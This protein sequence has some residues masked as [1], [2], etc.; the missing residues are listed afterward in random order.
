MQLMNNKKMATTNAHEYLVESASSGP[1]ATVWGIVGSSVLAAVKIVG[2][3]SYAAATGLCL[4]QIGEFS[5]VLATIAQTPRS[6][7]LI[8]SS[9]RY[10]R[11]S[12]M[13]IFRL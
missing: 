13:V 4:A 12:P 8:E 1:R 11:S 5:F 10:W 3:I 9:A 6:G 7:C 2:G